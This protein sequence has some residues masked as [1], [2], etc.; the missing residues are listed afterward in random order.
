MVIIPGNSGGERVSEGLVGEGPGFEE[1]SGGS[2]G[3]EK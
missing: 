1:G 3:E 2:S